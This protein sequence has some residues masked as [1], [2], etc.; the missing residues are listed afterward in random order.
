MG[1][2]LMISMIVWLLRAL[3]IFILLFVL[4]GWAFPSLV[5]LWAHLVFVPIMIVQWKVNSG[6][7]LLTDLE[8]YLLKNKPKPVH[9]EEGFVKKILKIFFK[10][11]PSD[12]AIEIGIY[13]VTVLAWLG[14]LYRII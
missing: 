11:L 7:C 6:N 9:T 2:V 14:T 10:K 5:V 3:H 8:N 12:K 4:F 13:V 1:L